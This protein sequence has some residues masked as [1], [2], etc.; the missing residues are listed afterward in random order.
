MRLARVLGL[1]LTVF[2]SLTVAPVKAA[3]PADYAISAGR[4]FTQ[5]SSDPAGF[6]GFS[7]VDDS[8]A[9]LWTEL[10]RY[11]GVERLGYPVSRRYACG[12]DVCQAFQK[13][14]LAWDRAAGIALPSAILDELSVAGWDER[15]L[16]RFETPLPELR[17][18]G[19]ITV[20]SAAAEPYLALLDADPEIRA[21]YYAEP[22]GAARFGLPTGV[23]R[24]DDAVVV[25]FQR[26]VVQRWLVNVP[27][28]AQGTITVANVGEL[29]REAGLIPTSAL[30]VEEQPVASLVSRDLGVELRVGP[31]DAAVAQILPAVRPAI[32]RVIARAQAGPGEAAVGTAAAIDPA[33]F[34]IT[35]GHVVQGAAR[36]EAVFSDGH[37]LEA[38]LVGLDE[39]NDLALLQVEQRLTTTIP[40]ALPSTAV[41]GMPVVASGYG[42]FTPV[43]P[44]FKVGEIQEIGRQ[45]SGLRDPLPNSVIQ[46]TAP[47][48][49]GDSGGPLLD[50]EGRLIGVSTARVVARR[51][52]SQFAA[53]AAP[54]DAVT[55]LLSSVRV[56]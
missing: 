5:T 24:F 33:G 43:E 4:F 15:L 11:G 14:V 23:G 6:Q 32:A 55:T 28:A 31:P 25:R 52:E 9:S 36:I 12:S 54:V 16:D 2:V 46:T 30:A 40:L 27:W 26:A 38:R 17:V 20:P 34:L 18:E 45:I 10:E 53:I 8:M 19:S 41:V 21:F 51:S 47:L 7:V 49:P 22:G 3:E 13:S 35:A 44:N 1:L 50:L 42:L 37:R 48:R 39:S 56:G 29:A